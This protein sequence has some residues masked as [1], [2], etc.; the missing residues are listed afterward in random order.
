MTGQEILAQAEQLAQQISNADQKQR[1]ALSPQFRAALE[2]L[3]VQGLRVPDRLRC[4]NTALT[5]E[6]VEALFDNMPV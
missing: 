3:E 5:E 4:L 6:S 1:L 2:H